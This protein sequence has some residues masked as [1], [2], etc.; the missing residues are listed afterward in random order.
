MTG[1]IDASTIAH[2]AFMN[3]MY[4]CV[5]NIFVG[6]QFAI[7]HMNIPQYSLYKN[8]KSNQKNKTENLVTNICPNQIYAIK[9]LKSRFSCEL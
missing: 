5:Y 2:V 3:S 6:D 4:V 8:T 1:M 9:D 7:F